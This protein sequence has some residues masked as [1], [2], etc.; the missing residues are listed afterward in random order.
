[1]FA[2]FV[3][4]VCTSMEWVVHLVDFLVDNVHKKQDY[5]PDAY[6]VTWCNT[7][8]VYHA[9]QDIAV[10]VKLHHRIVFTWQHGNKK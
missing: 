7:D 3:L 4:K 1:M 5:V 6:K 9:R 2:K 8:N 10:A